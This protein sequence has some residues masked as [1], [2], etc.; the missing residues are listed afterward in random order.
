VS[1]IDHDFLTNPC[2]TE[3][4]IWLLLGLGLTIN[5]GGKLNF[6]K[7]SDFFM[8]GVN[9][10]SNLYGDRA[11][12]YLIN[13]FSVTAPNF[14]KNLVFYGGPR[15]NRGVVTINSIESLEE[16]ISEFNNY[17]SGIGVNLETDEVKSGT[18]K[19]IFIVFNWRI[20]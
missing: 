3:S 8:T 14:M 1:E 12:I 17:F 11:K 13:A 2:F 6:K 18:F 4:L 16:H 20:Y 15:V 9:I 19:I 5:D 7:L 10:M